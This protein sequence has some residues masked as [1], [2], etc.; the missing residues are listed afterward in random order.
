MKKLI[1]ILMMTAFSSG[2]FAETA[3]D[4]IKKMDAKTQ[5][6]TARVSGVM[7]NNDRLGRKTS[8]FVSWSRGSQDFLIEFTSV[9]ESGQKVLRVDD[10]VY[11]YY[12]D[13]E[14][15][16]PMYGAAL[17]Q[18]MFGD[19]SYEDMTEGTDTLDKYDVKLAGSE[20]IDGI[21]CYVIDM[22]AKS[23]KVPYPKQK[24]WISKEEYITWKAQMFSKSGKL[25]K[26]MFVKE[27][28]EVNGIV[29]TAHMILEDK[30][31][32][33][34]STEMMMKEVE[35]DLPLDDDLF[36]LDSLR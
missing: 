36:S 3:E 11:L 16:I 28:K 30:L 29:F 22:T 35:L 8:S 14:E 10:T 9:E 6:D 23:K 31:K 1:S 2:V 12:P 19:I 33:N 24:A 15:L 21:D 17:K 18:S 7:I 25:L 27:V 32:R 5:Y 20:T 26:E 34:T 13:A 4:I